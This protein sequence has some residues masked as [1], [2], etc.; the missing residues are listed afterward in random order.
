MFVANF[1]GQVFAQAVNSQLFPIVRRAISRRLQRADQ[2]R[3][4]QFM[5]FQEQR[6][7]LLVSLG[8]DERDGKFLFCGCFVRNLPDARLFRI[9]QRPIHLSEG[10]RGPARLDVFCGDLD[11]DLGSSL[12]AFDSKFNR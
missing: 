2:P 5:I 12:F 8:G 7:A 4:H 10:V 6:I 11:C 3:I 1:F 9:P